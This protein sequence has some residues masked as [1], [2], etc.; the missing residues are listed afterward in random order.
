MNLFLGTSDEAFGSAYVLE[1]KFG[2]R[3]DVTKHLVL[4]RI[5][6]DV[7]AGNVSQG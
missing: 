6:Q 7:S 5:R 1:T 4:T 3:Y 2:L